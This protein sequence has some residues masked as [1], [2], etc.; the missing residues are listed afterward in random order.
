[1]GVAMCSSWPQYGFYA[2][3][4]LRTPRGID[5]GVFSV[6]DMDSREKDDP[7]IVPIMQDISRTIMGY[8]ETRRFRDGQRR[9]DRMV[10]GVGSFVQGKS[11]A[12][13][14]E[15]VPRGD[16]GEEL[17][18]SQDQIEGIGSDAEQGTCWDC[19]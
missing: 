7:N 18:L 12:S 1:M 19:T 14:W 9:A 16:D 17:D 5:I 4:P 3:V 6:L 8:L 15:V 2:G 10:K 11:T 13:G